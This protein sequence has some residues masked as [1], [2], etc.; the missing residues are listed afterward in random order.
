MLDRSFSA[1]IQ[2]RIDQKTK[3]LGA[4]G[5][6]ERVAH[7]LALIQSQNQDQAVTQLAIHQPTVLVFAADHG[8]AAQGVSIAPSA[9]T[10]QMVQNFLAGGAAINC[11][12]RTEHAAM[13]VIDCG[14]LRAHPAHADLIEQ[15]LGA[16]TH[17]LAE[18]AAMSSEQVQQG[19]ALG[20]AL[21][22]RE[23]ESGC[24]LLMFG[25]MGIGNTSSAAAIL[26][27]LS[28]LPIEVCVGRG[29][30]ITDEQ[31]QRKRAL[32]T[33]G[34]ERCLGAAPQDVLQQ[35]GGF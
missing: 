7:H 4:L 9:V 17:N 16:G 19:I 15:R 24:N 27:A 21:I 23:V 22:H 32:V 10:E 5:Q 18:Q 26:A 29:T 1:E 14:I 20:K 12:C 8:I 31:Y 13:R 6:L 28:G 2:Q 11:F 3:P 25:E 35:V 33:Q 34:V 30:G